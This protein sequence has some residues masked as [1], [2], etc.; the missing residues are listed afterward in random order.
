[1]IVNLNMPTPA[2]LNPIPRASL[3]SPCPPSPPCRPPPH[4][5]PPALPP[6]PTPCP[7]HRGPP[8]PAPAR[9]TLP[10]HPTLPYPCRRPSIG[11]PPTCAPKVPSSALTRVGVFAFLKSPWPSWPY[12]P[13][14]QV[15]TR[16]SML[17]P[18]QCVSPHDT[19][20]RVCVC[21]GG[22]HHAQPGTVRLATRHLQRHVCVGGVRMLSG[23]LHMTGGAGGGGPSM[24][25]ARHS[26]ERWWGEAECGVRWWGEAEC[27]VQWWGE[28]ECGVR[29][30]GEAECGC[31]KRSSV[32]VNS[33]STAQW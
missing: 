4:A 26:G 21:G 6:L 27:G 15:N 29:W 11:P 14:P 1:M 32:L 33:G 25:S 12:L 18:A 22:G 8:P 16:P 20:R 9:P 30:W 31:G 10:H 23:P 3:G 7:P 19:C 5:G 24:L 17:S 13:R 28:A 2:P